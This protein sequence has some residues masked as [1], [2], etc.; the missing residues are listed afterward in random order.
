MVENQNEKEGTS[1]KP[2]EEIL[3]FLKLTGLIEY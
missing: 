2:R 3:D 1:I